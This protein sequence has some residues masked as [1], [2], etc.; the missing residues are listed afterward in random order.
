MDDNLSWRLASASSTGITH[1]SKGEACQDTACYLNFES[2]YT[3]KNSLL[4]VLSDGA[5]SARHASLGSKLVCNSIVEFAKDY[6]ENSKTFDPSSLLKESVRHAR[7]EIYK[8]AK[9][10]GNLISDYSS[11]CLCLLIT[12]ESFAALQIG[13]GLIVVENNS[14]SIGPIFWPRKYEYANMTTF[15]TSENWLKDLQIEQWQGKPQ[16]FFI[17]SD[18]IQ[19]ICSYS[20]SMTVVPSFIDAFK[21]VLCHEEIGYSDSASKKILAFLESES[22]C[23]R[24]DDDKTI[25]VGIKK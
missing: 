3:D 16:T 17:C 19:S 11:T 8:I 20:R 7:K 25:L 1:A 23:S 4:L 14:G 21:R 22:V 2:H 15:I 9:A 18:G 6:L 13:D 5:G 24:T 10:D 12:E